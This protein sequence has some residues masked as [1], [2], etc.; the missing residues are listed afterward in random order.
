MEAVTKQARAW[1]KSPRSED[2]EDDQVS[3][4]IHTLKSNQAPN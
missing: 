4:F 1:K 3:I 2:F